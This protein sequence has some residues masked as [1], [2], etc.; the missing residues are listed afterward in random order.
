[1]SENPSIGGLNPPPIPPK[2]PI[3][4]DLP[5]FSS[6]SSIGSQISQQLECATQ[7]FSPHQPSL[8]N[9][10]VKKTHEGPDLVSNNQKSVQQ[11][12]D[13]GY[14]IPTPVDQSTAA[15]KDPR[16]TTKDALPFLDSAPSSDRI[17]VSIP[18]SEPCEVINNPADSGNPNSK[19][20]VNIA[21]TGDSN[22]APHVG[23]SPP[24]ASAKL[25]SYSPKRGARNLRSRGFNPKS[26]DPELD[27]SRAASIAHDAKIQQEFDMARGITR[28]TRSRSKQSSVQIA[29]FGVIRKQRKPVKYCPMLANLNVKEFAKKT[30]HVTKVYHQ[31]MDICEEVQNTGG[32]NCVGKDDSIS[33][34]SWSLEDEEEMDNSGQLNV[35]RDAEVQGATAQSVLAENDQFLKVQDHQMGVDEISVDQQLPSMDNGAT[36]QQGRYGNF[37]ITS[38]TSAQNVNV[39]TTLRSG[40]QGAVLNMQGHSGHKVGQQDDSWVVGVQGAAGKSGMAD[41]MG[42]T[43]KGNPTAQVK[44]ASVW[45][46][47]ASG[48]LSYGEMIKK[49]KEDND[50]K[51]EYYPPTITPEGNTRIFISKEDLLVS[52]QVYPLHLYGYFLGTSMDF[53]AVD[54]CF[55]RLWRK[56]DIDEITKSPAGIFYFKFKSEKG[57]N[58]VLENGPWMVN[59]IPIFLDKWVPGLCLEK[60]EPAIVPL[61]VT[62]HN[63][64][65]D[66]WTSTGINKLMSGMGEPKLMDKLTL[67]RCK[68]QTGKLGY[69][70]VLVD[71]KASSSLPCEVEVVYPHRTTKLQVSYQRKPPICSHCVVF[72]HNLKQCKLIPK[73]VQDVAMA[74]VNSNAN[75]PR[76]QPSCPSS[77][78]SEPIR[79][80][81]DQPSCPSA[82]PN[83]KNNKAKGKIVDDE[84]FETVVTKKSGTH[85][86]PNQNYS[87]AAS[88]SYQPSPKAPQVNKSKPNNAHIGTSKKPPSAP[89]K[90][91]GFD[92]NRAVQGPKQAQ[93]PVKPRSNINSPKPQSNPV[94]TPK[95]TSAKSAMNSHPTTQNRFAVLDLQAS[96]ESGNLIEESADLYPQTSFNEEVFKCTMNQQNVIDPG[97]V[98]PD[99]SRFSPSKSLNW[100]LDKDYGI[101]D[102]QKKRILDALR[103]DRKAVKAEDQEEW[104][105]GEWEFFYDK[106]IELDLDPDFC[107]EDVYEDESGSAQFISQLAKTAVVNSST[108]KGFNFCGWKVLKKAGLPGWNLVNVVLN[109]HRTGAGICLIYVGRNFL[110]KNVSPARLFTAQL[111]GPGDGYVWFWAQILSIMLFGGLKILLDGSARPT[112]LLASSLFL[113]GSRRPTSSLAHIV[114]LALKSLSKWVIIFV[115]LTDMIWA[116]A[117]VPLPHNRRPT[118]GLVMVCFKGPTLL[119]MYGRKTFSRLYVDG[120]SESLEKDIM[121]TRISIVV[122]IVWFSFCLALCLVVPKACFGSPCSLVLGGVCPSKKFM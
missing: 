83:T 108:V 86:A 47:H 24:N 16:E 39:V 104:V 116:W 53:R 27:A 19:P 110:L 111:K 50:V 2:P 98:I 31:E 66:L 45:D 100:I 28:S 6:D 118:S 74:D 113:G 43:D 106:C 58:E 36:A 13:S 73:P 120:P 61:W 71:V 69:A 114:F 64:P 4:P 49:H 103:G 26:G 5:P 117:R 62:I 79:E 57:L 8:D 56:F 17:P 115:F 82:A 33:V 78:P 12:S 65:L 35:T 42:T 93:N 75:G 105:D 38:T 87:A 112:S 18:N 48:P 20:K 52:A 14:D 29:G 22:L 90:S 41:P 3:P 54:R 32:E 44:S 81:N 40:E 37:P 11:H 84:G 51:M 34:H 102:D 109:W 88:C 97:R 85:V 7:L 72:G 101:T 70:R 15:T 63:I 91:A 76:V 10:T 55:H 9:A 119:D 121:P 30:R 21:V 96:F 25:P 68:N 107:V 92:F 23:L 80:A 94:P 59:N 122:G 95:T 46:R 77:S 89:K 67:E 99:W 60:V 1:M